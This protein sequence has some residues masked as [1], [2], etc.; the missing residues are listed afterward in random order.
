M[1]RI[2]IQ[3]LSAVFVEKFN[4]SKA[5][6]QR[7]VTTFFSLIQEGL[8]RDNLVKING[9][10]TFK[11]INVD[12]RESV[13]VNTGERV[14]IEG[15]QKISFQPDALMKEMVNKPFSGFETVVI[16]DGVVFEEISDVPAETEDVDEEEHEEEFMAEVEQPETVNP[17]IDTEA[18]DAP[19]LDFGEETTIEP[20]EPTVPTIEEEPV[21]A[22]EPKIEEHP[23]DADND[24][25]EDK[26]EEKGNNTASSHEMSKL[27][28]MLDE[29]ENIKPRIGWPL[30][31]AAIVACLVSFGIGYWL[32]TQKTQ[33]KVEDAI[34]AENTV[35]Q[36]DNDSI[37]KTAADSM[38]AQ[39]TAK[40]QKPAEELPKPAAA[41]EK[42]SDEQPV[43][44]KYEAMDSR[45]RTG[46]YR[47]VGTETTVKARPGMT[48]KKIARVYIGEE[49]ACYIAAY[50]DMKENDTLAAGQEIKIPKLE[51]KKKKSKT[52][53]N[54]Q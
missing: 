35:D 31:A 49:L 26:E 5:E 8:E 3:E 34:V 30:W 42:K 50:N 7:F 16:N 53:E 18:S 33:L 27:Q 45:I 17:K 44:D 15:H 40:S 38:T 28:I 10:G 37:A 52:K 51:W 29:P 2:A 47:I 19:L 9:L 24:E 13:N 36:P 1:S 41:E 12:E 20:N 22:D 39:N 21:N 46:A 25:E 23:E 4:M 14:V 48:I 11:V 54:K 6:A 32:G 43:L